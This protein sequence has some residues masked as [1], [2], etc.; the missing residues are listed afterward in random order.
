M[1]RSGT[2]FG[3]RALASLAPLRSKFSIIDEEENIVYQ[4]RRTMRRDC[5]ELKTNTGLTE[6]KYMDVVFILVQSTICY[7]EVIKNTL[8]EK[9]K[10][11]QLIRSI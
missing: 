5:V 1:K 6:K 4:S 7:Y 8:V 3:K 11:I 10:S 9:E 2:V